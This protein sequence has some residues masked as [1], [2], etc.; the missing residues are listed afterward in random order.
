MEKIM[1]SNSVV[2]SKLEKCEK[3]PKEYIPYSLSE[4]DIKDT[5]LLSPAIRNAEKRTANET[6]WYKTLAKVLVSML[7]SPLGCY[8]EDE[9]AT[10]VAMNGVINKKTEEKENIIYTI[11]DTRTNDLYDICNDPDIDFEKYLGKKVQIGYTHMQDCLSVESIKE[12][13]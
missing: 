13:K 9:P 6:P 11:K 7:G 5:L 2:N 12:I 8:F 10:L 1:S 3:S 4:R